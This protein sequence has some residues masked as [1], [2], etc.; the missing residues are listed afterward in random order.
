V[1]VASRLFI[2]SQDF[3]NGS[4]FHRAKGGPDRAMNISGDMCLTERRDLAFQSNAVKTPTCLAI[5]LFATSKVTDAFCKASD[6][7]ASSSRAHKVHSTKPSFTGG[8]AD[9]NCGSQVYHLL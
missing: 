3:T 9:W 4:G 7:S 8:C 2:A 5:S 1:Q 6:K